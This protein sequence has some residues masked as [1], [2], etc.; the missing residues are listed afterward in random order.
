MIIVLNTSDFSSQESHTTATSTSAQLDSCPEV[1]EE[2][3]F[4][5][6]MEGWL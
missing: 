5:K 2:S 1:A 6:Q 3:Q 4:L